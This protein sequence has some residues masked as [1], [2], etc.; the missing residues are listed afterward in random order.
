MLIGQSITLFGVKEPGLVVEQDRTTLREVASVVTRNDQLLWTAIAMV[1]FMTSFVTTT[2]FGV[3]FFKYAYGDE[4]M[5]SPFAAVLGVGQLLGFALFPVVR[6][7]LSRRPL[8]T[9]AFSLM[10]A[11]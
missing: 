6:R 2:S 1:L 7:Y 5:Y 9:L 10:A 8:F 11:G 4:N 3:Y